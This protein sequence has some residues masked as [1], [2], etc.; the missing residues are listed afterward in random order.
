M[1]RAGRDAA[2]REIKRHHTN[3]QQPP[4]TSPL[5]TAPTTYDQTYYTPPLE[6][7]LELFETNI[8]WNQL[9]QREIYLLSYTYYTN[10]AKSVSLYNIKTTAN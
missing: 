3:L 10:T 1:T 2:P 7:Y 6:W 5:V 9:N 8:W 4:I